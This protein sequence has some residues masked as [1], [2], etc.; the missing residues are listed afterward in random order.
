M[1]STGTCDAEIKIDD[2]VQNKSYSFSSVSS[3][4]EVWSL[5][6]GLIDAVL[7]SNHTLCI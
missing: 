3:T 4:I 1:P 5:N 6:F 7:T 2:K